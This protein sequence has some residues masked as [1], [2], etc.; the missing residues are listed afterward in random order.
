MSEPV[1]P[2]P[3][4]RKRRPW[5]RR[6]LWTAG[7]LLL[8][9]LL[10]PLLVGLPP[11]RDAI[12]SAAG[13]AL[14]RRVEIASASAY[15]GRG[16]DLEGITVHSP[17]GFDG[18]LAAVQKVHADVDLLALLGGSLSAR[19]RIVEPHVT[20]RTDERGRGNEDGIVEHVTRPDAR[21]ASEKGPASLDLALTLVG[22]RVET[23]PAGGG[24]GNVVD[25]IQVSLALAPD[26]AVRAQLDAAVRNA[27][28]EGAD[29]PIRLAAD[30]DSDGRGPVQASVPPIDL[31]RV[32]RVVESVSGVR[33]LAGRVSLAA[34]ATLHPD[35]NAAG[36]VALDVADLAAVL[37]DEARLSVR[38]ASARAKLARVE[39]GTDADVHVQISDVRLQRRAGGERLSFE[40]PSIVLAALA[41]YLPGQGLL[42]VPS[43]RVDAGRTASIEI[44]EPLRVETQADVRLEGRC[45]GR[46]DLGRVGELRALVPA[47]EP[48]AGGDLSFN[49]QGRG[50]AGLDVG[51][52]LTVRNLG[53][54]PSALAPD[55]YADRQVALAFNARHTAAEGARVTLHRLHSDLLQ[56]R[57]DQQ[58]GLALTLDPDG[59]Y[60]VDGSFDLRVDLAHLSR[61][62]PGALG[63]EPGERIRGA[64]RTLGQRPRGRERDAGGPRG[65]GAA[66]RRSQFV[67]RGAAAGLPVRAARR[68]AQRRGHRA[69]PQR[70]ARH[71]PGRQ[72]QR[73]AHGGRRLRRRRHPARRPRAGAR[74]ARAAARPRTARNPG[75]HA[76]LHPAPLRGRRRTPTGRRRP[77]LR[78]RLAPRR[79]RA[80]GAGAAHDAERQ[81]AP[82]RRGGAA[83][84][85][86]AHVRRGRPAP[87]SLRLELRR[88]IRLGPRRH[89]APGRRRRA[90]RPAAG[91]RARRGL[92]GSPRPGA[93]GGAGDAARLDGR[94]RAHPAGGRRSAAR[95]LEHGGPGGERRHLDRHAHAC[96][97]SPR[98]LPSG[99]G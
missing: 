86:R 83:R 10:A 76:D 44:R 29:V 20:L 8:V 84:G 17:E 92:R 11:V 5:L 78:S 22:G 15:W 13:E 41:R 79:R 64:V 33:G 54:R 3:T 55:G 97:G 90:P 21:E 14:D 80:P 1:T 48:L 26:G 74:V 63:L 23:L 49:V 71:G 69:D 89:A 39:P 38:R 67:E 93:A 68:A 95:H 42:E 81:R 66:R 16:I 28:A 2:P 65:G 77:P 9:V 60:G 47:L 4:P 88:R 6:L 34:D 45:E 7:V 57:F 98:A 24:A 19:M 46:L 31:S 50:G 37:P 53:L 94:R 35:R 59:H 40:E 62:V 12:A 56:G 52:A 30:L 70:P 75:G 72:G 73:P 32:A 91:R 18:P 43:G 87:G 51:A 96:G 61:L 85:R 58:D 99:P 25:G 36:T 27:G 82:G